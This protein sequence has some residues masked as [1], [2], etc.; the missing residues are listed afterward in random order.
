MP[1]HAEFSSKTSKYIGKLDPITKKRIEEK[2]NKLEENPFP[3]EVERVEDFEGEKVFR[4]RI[5]NQRI[6]YIVRYDQQKI[7]II[8]VDKRPRVYKK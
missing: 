5:G 6:L 7:I 8:K 1:F 4:V 2:V 3:Q